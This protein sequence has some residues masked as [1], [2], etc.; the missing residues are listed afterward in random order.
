MRAMA[1]R[2]RRMRG[3]RRS[4]A[5]SPRISARGHGQLAAPALEVRRIARAPPR[6]YYSRR[7]PHREEERIQPQQA[8]GK[9]LQRQQHAIAFDQLQTLRR[10][11]AH[12][13]AAM[14]AHHRQRSVYAFPAG[15]PGA[16]A[17]LGVVAVCEEILVEAANLVEHGLAIEGGGA[18][19]PQDFFFAVELSVVGRTAA[20]AAILA[21]GKN[22][23]PHLVDAAG[24]FPNHHFA[25][26]HAHFR[27]A[28]TGAR[29]APPAT[30]LGFRIV[31]QQRDELAPRQRNSLVVGRA[32]AAVFPVADHPRSKLGFGQIRGS[33]GGTIV[34]HNCFEWDAGL[35]RQGKQTG[36]Q[37][38][39][40]VPVHHYDGDQPFMLAGSPFQGIS[41]CIMD[42]E[43][44][45]PSV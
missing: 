21:V 45:E 38:L 11:L 36:A 26:R 29:A 1:A 5:R 34:D 17:Q 12:G 31:V 4:A 19:R 18:I 7:Q 41:C 22:Q 30:G 27:R 43:G 20:A 10:A 35:P 40:P 24:L 6:Q 3:A 23:V 32:E 44:W 28:R 8:P 16:K 9:K 13:R 39:L 14:M 37:Q 33:V 42:L 2:L 25:G 15:D